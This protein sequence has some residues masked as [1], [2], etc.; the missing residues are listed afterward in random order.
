MYAYSF[1]SQVD[2]IFSHT[3][4]HRS[5]I[6]V[7]TLMPWKK[8]WGGEGKRK[9]LEGTGP[10]EKYMIQSTKDIDSHIVLHTQ[11]KQFDHVNFL[12]L[13][14][15]EHLCAF[16]MVTTNEHEDPMKEEPEKLD[17][18]ALMEKPASCN[19][20][21]KKGRNKYPVQTLLLA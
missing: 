16:A 10:L 4:G 13:S 3:M 11:N 15:E 19:E 9:K 2:A 7:P 5:V 20:N 1:S 14:S 17:Y 8:Q 18:E 6:V 12:R 21:R